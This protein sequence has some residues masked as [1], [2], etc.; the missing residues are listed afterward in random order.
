M[1]SSGEKTALYSGGLDDS[2]SASSQTEET[3]PSEVYW[4]NCEFVCQ[5]RL[6]YHNLLNKGRSFSWSVCVTLWFQ[7]KWVCF[8]MLLCTYACVHLQ[9][10]LM[11]DVQLCTRFL[12]HNRLNE[13]VKETSHCIYVSEYLLYMQYIY[14][15]NALLSVNTDLKTVLLSVKYFTLLGLTL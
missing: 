2:D 9:Y 15:H 13:T 1:T 7:R 10:V 11:S 3:H 8:W 12:F 6:I 4:D 14:K 5:T